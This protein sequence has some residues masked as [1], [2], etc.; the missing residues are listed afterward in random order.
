MSATVPT[1]LSV[2]VDCLSIDSFQCFFSLCLSLKLRTSRLWTSLTCEYSF[3]SI[4]DLDDFQQIVIID[5]IP[6]VYTGKPGKLYLGIF[7]NN[8]ALCI[9]C[10]WARAFLS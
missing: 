8:F 1:S 4:V 5:I 3:K 7:Q 9:N 10:G 2:S 6:T